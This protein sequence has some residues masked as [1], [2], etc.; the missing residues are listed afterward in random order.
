LPSGPNRHVCV[1]PK[2]AFLHVAVAYVK[3]FKDLLYDHEIGIGVA[4]AAHFGF[5]DD[6]DERCAAPVD[7]KER[8]GILVVDELAGVLLKMDACYAD[9]LFHAIGL[10]GDFSV[11]AYGH[12]V[13]G[14][15]VA[16]RQIR[17]KIVLSG[18][19]RLARNRAIHRESHAN[20]HIDRR[21]VKNRKGAGKTETHRASP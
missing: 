20:C 21:A 4:G 17:I 3:I 7:I 1:A 10:Y 15:L 2:A 11:F 5:A 14:Y 18:E 12:V 8:V 9:L 19:Y 16:L 13:L 6:F